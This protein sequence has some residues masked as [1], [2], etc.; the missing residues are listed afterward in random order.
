MNDGFEFKEEARQR[1]DRNLAKLRQ[2]TTRVRQ[3]GDALTHAAMCL[4]TTNQ[5]L[6]SLPLYRA[7]EASKA[8]TAYKPKPRPALR[9][10]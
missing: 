6:Q 7:Y 8:Q 9:L 5:T 10:V 4:Q 1:A 3:I 2:I